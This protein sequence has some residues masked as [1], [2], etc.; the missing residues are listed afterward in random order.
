MLLIESIFMFGQTKKLKLRIIE[1]EDQVINIQERM[2]KVQEQL[3]ELSGN[4]ITLMKASFE[5]DAQ[6]VLLLKQYISD[7]ESVQSVMILL[8]Q[9]QEKLERKV[10]GRSTAN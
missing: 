1:L 10:F 4:T 7:V 8:R 3:K 9:N 6:L 2:I 5:R